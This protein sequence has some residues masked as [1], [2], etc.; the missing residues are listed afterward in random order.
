MHDACC[1]P[2]LEGICDSPALLAAFV[3]RKKAL[4]VMHNGK[5][6]EDFDEI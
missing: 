6:E 4:F 3:P 1:N 5:K 2:S